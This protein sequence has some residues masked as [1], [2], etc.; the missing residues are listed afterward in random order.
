MLAGTIM[1]AFNLHLQSEK[2][3]ILSAFLPIG[4]FMITLG[5]NTIIGYSKCTERVTAEC[6]GCLSRRHRGIEC[7]FPKFRY[8]YEGVTYVSIGLVSYTPKQFE[9]LFQNKTVDIYINPKRPALCADKLQSPMTRSISIIVIG[10]FFILVAILL[11]VLS[12]T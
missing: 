7:R 1:S 9:E 3:S 8:R 6:I 11:C 12:G 10:G 2:L 4:V 5:L